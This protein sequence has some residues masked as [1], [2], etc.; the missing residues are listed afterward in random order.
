MTPPPAITVQ[1]A[2]ST[3]ELEVTRRSPLIGR[4]HELQR[5][6]A[7]H[8]AV[9]ESGRP[10]TVAVTGASGIGK[11]RLVRE[12]LLN[13][14]GSR[15]YRAAA[16]ENDPGFGVFGRLLRGRFGLIEGAALDV[17]REKLRAGLAELF[18]DRKV[19]DV[20]YLLGGLMGIEFQ[21]SP[22][23]K[24]LASEPEQLAMSRRAV[25]QSLIDLDAR[26]GEG[27]LVLVVDDMHHAHQDA[28]TLLL[29]L[30]AGACSPV[31]FVVVGRPEL[32]ARHDGW[33]HS[34][35]LARTWLEVGP[36]DDAESDQ[37]MRE[38]LAP[39]ATDS[40]VQVEALRDLVDY[41]TSLA[42][43]NPSLL[44]QM[45]HV[46]HD[47]GVLTS[48]DPFSEYE[49]WTIHPERMDEARLP[50]TIEDAVFARIS[51][52]AP[53]EREL[54]E[55]AAVMGGVFWLGGLL[56]IE[57]AGKS[58]PLFWE[59]GHEYDRSSAEELLAE[60][61]E[62]D[63]VLKL[64]DGTFAGEVE[65]VFKHNLERET[66]ARGVPLATSRRWHHAIAEW[67]SMRDGGE[68]GHDPP[69]TGGAPQSGIGD[70]EHLT[71]LARHYR[72]GGR[73]LRAG[74]TYFRAAAA[75]RAQHANAKAAEL[76]F[77]GV[78]LL[79]E[80]D[81]VS[82]ETWLRVHHDHGD[83]LHAIGKNDM[84][85]DAYREMLALAYSLDL[86][87]K[88]GA[89][90][91]KLGRLFRDTGCLRDAEEHLQA[92]LTLFNQVRDTRGM[93]ST[94]DDL[95]KVAW[96]RGDSELAL[97]MTARALASRRALGDELSVAVS[98]NNLGLI[99]QA[100]GEL[101]RA[102]E[103]FEETLSM[104]REL[105]DRVGVAV[106]L[107]NLGT[108]AQGQGD[109]KRALEMYLEALGVA[110][111]AGDK[112]RQA[113]ILGHVG[114]TYLRLLDPAQALQ[115]VAR[116]DK[117]ADELGDVV[118][119]A[120]ALRLAAKAHLQKEDAASARAELVKAVDLYRQAS[121]R[122]PYAQAL[123]ELGEAQARGLG[124]EA[125]A[126]RR[127]FLEAV[128]AFEGLGNDMELSRTLTA[129]A[130]FL[131]TVEPYCSSESFAKER[132]E[133]T[134]RAEQLAAQ[135]GNGPSSPTP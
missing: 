3:R 122:M 7:L 15:V 40:R 128:V 114:E 5:L 4:A 64:P 109:D 101:M 91:A 97:K 115:C 41:G 93:A 31:L 89:A 37:V 104:R 54:L 90:H 30:A 108:V 103:A 118:V 79:R 22:L 9:R 107:D 51:A 48:E 66:L 123:R 133:Q 113:D 1:D 67:L 71:A 12:F 42:H 131:T 110:K 65:Y 119:R 2:A 47:M 13:E 116:A 125:E 134:E 10:Q 36:L 126:A 130:K 74:L 19:G 23:L 105:G 34:Q 14:K 80:N 26:A 70:D 112:A 127:S 95:G 106:A 55:R 102:K 39:A 32:L 92:A 87:G 81:Q 18:G 76:Y 33:S 121:H 58:A 44:E 20:C 11:T 63:Y 27:Q 29:E 135:V 24:A 50:L 53:A 72:D 98:L 62:R 100:R 35:K 46:F 111:E 82:P 73:S 85:Q 83:A 52:L 88:G 49:K 96:L 132:A 8:Q 117:L 28:H 129:Y 59:R 99:L 86:P 78:M 43:G 94:T 77:E 61:T 25:L 75:S 60:L 16:R 21:D 124:P 69:K 120:G 17:T 68:A 57:R 45:V 6:R 38:L 56:A 84:A